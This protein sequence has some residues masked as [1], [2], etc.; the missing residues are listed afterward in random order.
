ML[1]PFQLL[2]VPL[3]PHL[4]LRS[5]F[6]SGHTDWLLCK[7]P[8]LRRGATQ[9]SSPLPVTFFLGLAKSST[10][11][12]STNCYCLSEG[13]PNYNTPLNFIPLIVATPELYFPQQ[14]SLYNGVCLDHSFWWLSILPLTT[15]YMKAMTLYFLL[16]YL[17]DTDTWAVHSWYGMCLSEHIS[18]SQLSCLNQY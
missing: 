7:P 13:F 9:T 8:G 5:F 6:C 2:L 15:Y 14:V 17:W 11:L 1:K 10:P 3:Q 18:F 12:V 16:S 4:F